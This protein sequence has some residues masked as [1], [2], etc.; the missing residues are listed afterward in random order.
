M[1][2]RE[3]LAVFWPATLLLFTPVDDLFV[4]SPFIDDLFVDDLSIDDLSV[5]DLSV[6][7]R[8]FGSIRGAAPSSRVAG[9]EADAPAEIDWREEVRPTVEL[10]K[11]SGKP[12]AGFAPVTFTGGCTAV[13]CPL[14]LYILNS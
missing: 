5:D 1:S 4:D 6:N 8:L 14:A 3:A 2:P 13:Q 10:R 7:G 9:V 11:V 12:A